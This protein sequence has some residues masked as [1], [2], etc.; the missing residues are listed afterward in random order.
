MGQ[1]E[2]MKELILDYLCGTRDS[3][4]LQALRDVQSSIPVGP[5]A[6]V[7]HMDQSL[8]DAIEVISYVA[9]DRFSLDDRMPDTPAEIVVEELASSTW[10]VLHSSWASHDMEVRR[11]L[12][13]RAE[14]VLLSTELMAA[15]AP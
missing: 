7:P 14:M 8:R 4:L 2:A 5:W 15:E 10:C 9:S 13:A 3:V 12:K 1:R 6:R 11:W